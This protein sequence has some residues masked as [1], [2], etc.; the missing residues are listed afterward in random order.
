[1]KISKGDIFIFAPAG[2]K[3]GL[4]ADSLVYV[5]FHTLTMKYR[6]LILS[7][8][9]NWWT[10]P[11]WQAFRD[12]Y[13]PFLRAFGGQWRIDTGSVS[14]YACPKQMW[15]H[16]ACPTGLQHVYGGNLLQSVT[17]LVK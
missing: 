3:A 15:M 7:V 13:E 11:H 9:K 8:P 1:M 5:M 14:A 17:N 6:I 10:E 4:N 12:N 16:A 2:V